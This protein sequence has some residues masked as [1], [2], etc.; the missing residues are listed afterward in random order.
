MLSE[1][2]DIW[3][4]TLRDEKD[5]YY[6]IKKCPKIDLLILSGHGSK[7]NILLNQ[8]VE[9][10]EE[11]SYIDIED[12]ELKRHLKHLD[13]EATIFLNACNTGNGRE[14]Q[15]NLANTIAEKAPGR[16]VIAA[17]QPYSI[18]E[19]KLTKYYPLALDIPGKAYSVKK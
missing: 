5:L 1:D 2:Y 19:I 15:V 7:E 18:Q 6:A 8:P 11:L 9:G 10:Y 16:H 13:P 14:N 17:T 12:K 4:A 3:F